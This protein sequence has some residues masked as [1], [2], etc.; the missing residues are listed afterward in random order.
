MIL[1]RDLKF[2]KSYFCRLSKTNGSVSLSWLSE[3]FEA[4]TELWLELL[5]E[6]D[7]LTFRW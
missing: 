5:E 1:L 7:E 4:G 3:E 2:Q 6:P